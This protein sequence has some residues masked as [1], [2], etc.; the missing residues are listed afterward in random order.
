VS[1][2]RLAEVLFQ[3]AAGLILGVLDCAMLLLM[4][5]GEATDDLFVPLSVT[6]FG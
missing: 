2:L 4:R 6:R 1:F 3:A 5:S